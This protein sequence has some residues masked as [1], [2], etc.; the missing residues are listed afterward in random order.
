MNLITTIIDLYILNKYFVIDLYILNKYFVLLANSGGSYTHLSSSPL[1]HMDLVILIM[2]IIYCGQS[3]KDLPTSVGSRE[4]TRETCD[5]L[6]LVKKG[7]T[8][9]GGKPAGQ[10]NETLPP[11]AHG[12][13]SPLPTHHKSLG[14]LA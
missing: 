2:H 5:P 1:L 7:E 6:I 12:L 10:V 8:T 11:L 9:E 13:D 14:E 4:G 3:V